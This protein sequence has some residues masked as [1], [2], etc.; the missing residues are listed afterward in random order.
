MIKWL[1]V[2]RAWTDSM[3]LM[4]FVFL[5]CLVFPPSYDINKSQLCPQTVII[6]FFHHYLSLSAT[7]QTALFSTAMTWILLMRKR[8]VQWVNVSG[9]WDK[10]WNHRIKSAFCLPFEVAGLSAVAKVEP[11]R[12][13][14]VYSKSAAFSQ[15]LLC[16]IK[17]QWG[18]GLLTC[19]TVK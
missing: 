11:D 8:P 19:L 16:E 4:W 7:S 14:R 9:T 15:I 1:Q 6:S 17:S 10:V 13:R 2:T 3:E 5:D 18:N 12:T